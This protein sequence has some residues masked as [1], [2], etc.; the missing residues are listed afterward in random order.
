MREG[1]CKAGGVGREEAEEREERG[2]GEKKCGGYQKKE[3]FMCGR[4]GR[5]CPP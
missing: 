2:A 5:E 4:R 3:T 1:V